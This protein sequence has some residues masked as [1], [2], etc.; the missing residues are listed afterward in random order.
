MT[1]DAIREDGATRP[2]QSF[3]HRHHEGLGENGCNV[4]LRLNQ[5]PNTPCCASQGMQLVP[6]LQL[7]VVCSDIS[8]PCL[9]RQQVLKYPGSTRLDH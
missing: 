2:C 9:D 5:S 6:S 7:D 3:D 8:I 1:F 4:P